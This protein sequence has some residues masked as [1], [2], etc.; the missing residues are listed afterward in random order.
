[1]HG[2]DDVKKKVIA[3]EK[4]EVSKLI[5]IISG[6]LL[7]A[8][9]ILAVSTVGVLPLFTGSTVSASATVLPLDMIYYGWHDTVT[10]QR[11]I[12][13]H[14][15]GLVSNSPAGP[16]HGNANINQFTSAGI[17]FYEYIDGGY[18]GSVARPIPDD[19]Q[20]NL[21]YIMAASKAGAYGIFLDEV[22]DGVYTPANYSYLQ[23]MGALAGL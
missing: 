5:N 17:K 15:L 9:V 6:K 8:T 23:P 21:N 19:L 10:D 7:I 16:W 1:M 4:L 12:A 2:C 3:G 18:E 11:I 22:S 20:S 14:P 13:A